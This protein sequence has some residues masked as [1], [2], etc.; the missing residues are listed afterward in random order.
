[1]ESASSRSARGDACG[2]ADAI[3]LALNAAGSADRICVADGKR[4]AQRYI[5][6]LP[7]QLA[8]AVQA[9]GH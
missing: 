9:C 4:L 2:T 7:N 1:M 3:E 8:R 6:L 5:A